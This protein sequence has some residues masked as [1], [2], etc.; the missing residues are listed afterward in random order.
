LGNR[1]RRLAVILTARR[2][3]AVIVPSAYMAEL[4]GDATPVSVVGEGL[5]PVLFRPA[6][7]PGRDIVYVSDFYPHKRHDLALQAWQRLREPRPALHFVGAPVE[8]S[9]AFK[10]MADHLETLG[11]DR[12]KLHGR[13]DPKQV[14]DA[15]RRARVALMPSEHESFS[16][17]VVEAASCGTPTVA[18]DLPVLRE[19]GGEGA[20]Y[21]PGDD[22]ALWAQAIDDLL[23]DDVRHRHLREEGIRHSAG[24]S[25]DGRARAVLA[26][27]AGA[28]QAS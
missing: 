2:A 6:A 14:A 7:V 12:V 13:L 22:P 1:L 25:W 18:R 20:V 4:F 10:E 24:F 11:D 5:D 23:A 19:T 17:P 21:V 8:G 26:A 9:R 3:A 16:L 28:G 15:Y 27:V